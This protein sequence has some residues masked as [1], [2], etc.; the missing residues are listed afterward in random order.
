MTDRIDLQP[1]PPALAER[2][3]RLF[4]LYSSQVLAY[5]ATRAKRPEDADDIAGV[6]WMKACTT[7]HRL[8]GP[9]SE[10][11]P[12]LMCITRRAAVDFYTPKR[13]AEQPRDWT[14][15][16]ASRPIPASPAVDTVTDV[17]ALADLSASQCTAIKLAAQGLTHRAIASRMGRSA[18]AVY[19]HLQRGARKLRV[20][21]EEDK[22]PL[23]VRKPGATNPPNPSVTRT[24]VGVPGVAA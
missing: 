6:A 12:W 24:Y 1:L 11:A 4:R 22:P 17:F 21:M 8:Q 9:D 16:V 5:A 18:G 3:D 20:R 19:S 23:P 13:A 15:A 2:L 10:A 14:D 7:I